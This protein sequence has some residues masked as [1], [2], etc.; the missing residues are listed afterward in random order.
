MIKR[1]SSA[2][3]ASPSIVHVAEL[4]GVS[5]ATASR[6]MSNSSYPVSPATRQKVLRA[7]AEL[8]YTPNSLARG[9]RSQRS[10]LLAVLV[11]DNVDHYFAEITRGV[12]EVANEHGYLTIVCNTDRNPAKELHYLQALRDYR[13]DGII[14]AG[15]GFNDPE[16]AERIEAVIN[17]MMGRGAAAVALAQHTLHIPSIQAD[18]FGGARDMTA[19]LIALGHRRIAFVTGPSN[20]TVANVR[21]QGYMAAMVENSLA[22]DPQLILPGNFDQASG[23]RAAQSI[24]QMPPSQRPTAVFAANDET[25]FGVILGLRRGGVHVPDNLSVCGFGDLPMAQIVAPPLTTV[26]IP[27]RRLG[28]SGA[29]ALLAMLDQRDYPMLE[30]LPVTIVERSSTQSPP[31]HV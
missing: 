21:L 22:I 2:G 11:G 14:F 4:A 25:A 13:T 7:A 27:L 12:E 18:N 6:V 24:I 9:L 10:K 17:E 30:I 16:H 1:S 31:T 26:H 29:L 19:R 5:V 23:E 3:K 8:G 20:L 15:S 28:R